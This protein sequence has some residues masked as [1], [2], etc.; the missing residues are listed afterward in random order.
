MKTIRISVS[1]KEIDAIREYAIMCD[2]SVSSIIKK[3]VIQEIAFMKSEPCG[4]STYDY[5][6]LV[7]MDVSINKEEQII[8]ANYNKIRQILGL[9]KIKLS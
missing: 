2:E 7:P 6:M 9:E 4:T 3:I 1:Q 8:E 5:N